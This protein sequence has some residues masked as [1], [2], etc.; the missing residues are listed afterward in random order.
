MV[1]ELLNDA[2]RPT[3]E[4]SKSSRRIGIGRSMLARHGAG[5]ISQHFIARLQP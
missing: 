3:P 5:G 1:E 4:I 2:A